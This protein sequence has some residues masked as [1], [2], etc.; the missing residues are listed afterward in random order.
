MTVEPIVE[1][2][3]GFGHRVAFAPNGQRWATSDGGALHLFRDATYER[4]E[5]TPDGRTDRLR[6]DSAGARVLLAPWIWDVAANVWAALPPTE[7]HL[8]DGIA[9]PGASG[10][11]E[12]RAAAWSPAGDEL[13]VYAGYRPSRRPGALNNFA[14][15]AERL[16]ALRGATRE[17][18]AMLW[19]GESLDAIRAIAIDPHVIV[20]G[21]ATL[22][23]WERVGHRKLADLPAHRLSVLDLAFS[24]DG[25]HLAS[26]G[27]DGLLAL[28]DTARWMLVASWQV[29]PAELHAVAFHPTRPMLA[30]GS[31]D[32]RLRFWSLGG[33][34]L[35]AEPLGDAVVALTF[36]PAGDRLL[37]AVSGHD[38]R[39]LLLR[40]K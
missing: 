11:F 20:A 29:T 33:E 26:G 14:G 8:A 23:V 27:T 36:S 16:L 1:L 9:D 6:F 24:P 17:V 32:G 2:R 34:F 15:P 38:A 12:C 35:H 21:G 19:Q 3:E 37:A 25:A 22:S 5:P 4:R 31:A 28:W 39:L 13:V 18:V 10:F 40:M 7:P 30:T